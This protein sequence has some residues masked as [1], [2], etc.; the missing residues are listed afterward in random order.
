MD[1]QVRPKSAAF[2]D[3]PDNKR[4]VRCDYSRKKPSIEK[5][6]DYLA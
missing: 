4:Y 1:W 2:T 5:T 6:I 3:F